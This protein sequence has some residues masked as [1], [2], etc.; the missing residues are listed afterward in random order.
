VV[1]EHADSLQDL[2][3]CRLLVI[4][5]VMLDCSILGK[6]TRVSPEAPVPVLESTYTAYAA[7][8]A[9]NVAANARQLG[10]VVDVVGVV[11]SDAESA[12]LRRIL[13][14]HEIDE[15]GIFTDPSRPTTTKTRVVAQNQQIVR[16]DRESRDAVEGSP[17][18]RMFRYAQ[19]RL[20]EVDI[21]VISDYAKGVLTPHRTAALLED[22]HRLGVPVLVDPKGGSPA[23]YTGASV[24][25][26]NRREVVR[27]AGLDAAEADDPDVVRAASRRLLAA[28]KCNAILV[29]QGAEGM[30]VFEARGGVT[31]I[32]AVI[33]EAYDSTG[34]GDTV[35]A[36]L[37]LALANGR[38]IADAARIASIA[39]GV[40]VTKIGTATVTSV[41]L[42]EAYDACAVLGAGDRSTEAMHS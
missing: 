8:G 32:P 4:G 38:S 10:A 7:G 14:E 9:A 26:P 30:T 24:V 20:P 13:L 18:R 35:A 33:R 5:D 1:A 23:K 28:L 41:E 31:A 27:L 12:R 16:V 40:V 2:G 42:S 39:A 36:V 15:A 11:G 29:T 34:A 25:T 17:A 3:S 37:A 19:E 21:V 22:A 6:V